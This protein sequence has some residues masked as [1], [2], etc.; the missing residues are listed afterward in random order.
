[1]LELLPSFPANRNK[2]T[3]E[4]KA[5]LDN[6]YWLIAETESEL[7]ELL[8]MFWSFHDF[9]IENVDYAAAPDRIDLLLE[10]DTH[11]FR[12]LLR[13]IGNVRMNFLPVNDYPVDWLT[14]SQLGKDKKGQVIWA[15]A[16]GIDVNALPS[17]V[18]WIAGD[19]LHYALLDEN[20]QAKKLP[21]DLVQQ[22]WHEL[23]YDTG[24]YEDIE[25][26][27]HPRFIQTED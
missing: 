4:E 26:G 17:D 12:V 2:I 5:I 11:E 14:D 24:E 7:N 21:K 27:F 8:D 1:M 19:I 3:A 10:Y 6:R 9:R 16:E 15:G 20:G 22:V 23:N 25:K 18:L 13:F